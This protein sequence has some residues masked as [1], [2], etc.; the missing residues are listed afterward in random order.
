MND[1]MATV[2]CNNLP[3]GWVLRRARPEEHS[4]SGHDF[5]HVIMSDMSSS[6]RSELQSERCIKAAM[7]FHEG[8]LHAGQDRYQGLP[9]KLQVTLARVRAALSQAFHQTEPGQVTT[10]VTDQEQLA[11][12]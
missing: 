4:L 7:D 1:A 2:R 5:Q 11:H 8:S 9:Y 12:E 3:A 6:I 10:V